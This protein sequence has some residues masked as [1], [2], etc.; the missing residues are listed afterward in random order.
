MLG[1]NSEEGPDCFKKQGKQVTKQIEVEQFNKINISEGIELIVK[2]SAEQRVQ[3]TAGENLINDISFEVADGELKIKDENGCGMFRDTSVAKVL[4][5]TPV[6]EKIYSASQFYIYSDGILTFPGLILETGNDEETASSLFEMQ[7][8]NE[9][10]TINDNVSSVFK[11]SG[12]TE[13]FQVNFW[14]ANGRLEAGALTANKINVFHRSTNDMIVS[15]IE[16]ISGT[17]YST[18]NLVLKNVPP[19]I[20]VEQ[21]YS[22]HIVYP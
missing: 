12:S 16:E 11:I 22:G 13:N 8:E 5:S 20:E 21:L 2:Q 4:V 7:I 18:G 14:G 6:L 3:V 19:V 9:S 1:C 17:I 10:L 15:P